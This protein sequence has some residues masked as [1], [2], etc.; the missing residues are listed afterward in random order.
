MEQWLRQHFVPHAELRWPM[1]HLMVDWTQKIISCIL[2]G[3]FWKCLFFFFQI[4]FRPTFAPRQQRFLPGVKDLWESGENHGSVLEAQAKSSWRFHTKSLDVV[5]G[6]CTLIGWCVPESEWAEVCGCR[7]FKSVYLRANNAN[8]SLLNLVRW[9]VWICAQP[10]FF[11][12]HVTYRLH[13]KCFLF[14][15]A[16]FSFYFK[17]KKGGNFALLQ[18]IYF[19]RSF[20]M[21]C[22]WSSVFYLFA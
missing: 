14:R 17:L 8:I 10:F 20:G 15:C 11:S 5:P 12:H 22:C 13:S 3:S 6:L 16:I 18:F 1:L 21:N 9:I 2:Q 4:S 19:A 7:L